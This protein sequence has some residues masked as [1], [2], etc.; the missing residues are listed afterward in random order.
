MPDLAP[1]VVA[2]V[3][4]SLIEDSLPF[5]IIQATVAATALA[6]TWAAAPG[7]D[8]FSWRR[9]DRSV[10]ELR[11]GRSLARFC[12]D[13]RK[14]KHILG[15]RRPWEG[16]VRCDWPRTPRLRELCQ[17]VNNIR[18]RRQETVID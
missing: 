7:L 11:R 2:R 8:R 1:V 16:E 10:P 15:G 6:A 12:D 5:G 14:P 17:Q 4:E 18:G 3:G 9:A 13:D